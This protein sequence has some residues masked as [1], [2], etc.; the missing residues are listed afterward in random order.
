MDTLNVN[1]MRNTVTSHW[2][3]L[4]LCALYL[5]CRWAMQWTMP[6]WN[7]LGI[8]RLSLLSYWHAGLQGGS[9]SPK[10]CGFF[11]PSTDWSGIILYSTAPVN[12][13]WRV[14]WDLE[15]VVS[16]GIY[17]DSE[18]SALVMKSHLN[19]RCSQVPALF[20]TK[21]PQICNCQRSSSSCC[22]WNSWRAWQDLLPFAA[23]LREEWSVSESC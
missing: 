3:N 7:Y 23:W 5:Q 8:S 12:K 2:C 1:L 4:N 15:C 6:W 18:E 14:L 17:Y 22:Y 19:A 9:C 11:S 21:P 20:K 16:N 13:E 10:L